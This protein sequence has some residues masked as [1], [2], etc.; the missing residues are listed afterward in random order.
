MSTTKQE[1]TF[2]V[3]LS[4]GVNVILAGVKCSVGVIANSHALIADGIHSLTD[5]AGD[6]AAIIGIRFA[7]LPKDDDHPYGHHRFSTLATLFISTLV[8]SFC[9]GLA[10]HSLKNLMQGS[11]TEIPGV[12][13]AWVAGI[14]LIIK[15]T[16]Y[17]FARRQAEKLGSRLL[18]ANAADHRAD[19]IASLLA[20]IAVVIAN[21]HPEWVAVDK[22]IGLV[23]AGWLGAEGIKLF[24][25]ACADL[26]DTAPEEKILKD[27]SEHILAVPGTKGFHAF[28]ARRV[29]DRFEIDFHLQVDESATVAQGHAIAGQVKSDILRLHPE[30]VSV[31][32]HV[33]P[34][35]PEYRKC[36]GHHG[37]AH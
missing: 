24:K 1:G 26:I 11:A 28:R 22:V 16:F 25:S 3:I 8:L 9:I 10:W 15:E 29:G 31:L 5:I 12:A 33:E 18:M 19:A 32:V 20:L 37:S 7:H 2:T 17:Q 4:L 13:A 14:A 35:M 27:L 6:I 34:D 30:V 21:T 36:D 23:L